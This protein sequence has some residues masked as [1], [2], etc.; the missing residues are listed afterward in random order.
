[1]NMN[2][3][4]I[5]TCVRLFRHITRSIYVRIIRHVRMVHLLSYKRGCPY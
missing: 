3:S 2:K 4:G 1:M 5:S